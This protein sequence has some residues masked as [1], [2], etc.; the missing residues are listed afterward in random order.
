MEPQACSVINSPRRFLCQISKLVLRELRSSIRDEGVQPDPAAACSAA[1]GKDGHS[2]PIP[3]NRQERFNGEI[4]SCAG[5][6][7]DV[8]P[9]DLRHLVLAARSLHR[10]RSARDPAS[11]CP[12]DRASSPTITSATRA[13]EPSSLSCAA[14]ELHDVDAIVIGLDQ[15]WQRATLAQRRER[16]RRCGREDARTARKRVSEAGIQAQAHSFR[17]APLGS[18]RVVRDSQGN[19]RCCAAGLCGRV[20]LFEHGED[21]PR[22]SVCASARTEPRYA[23]FRACF[24]S[25]RIRLCAQISIRE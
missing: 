3:A 13:F 17:P 22:S 6:R 4:Q 21:F 5:Q 23:G 7:N 24:E 12:R 2:Q 1:T 9:L 8:S 14:D 19:P 10:R 20:C 15:P 18:A 11:E 16:V 25:S